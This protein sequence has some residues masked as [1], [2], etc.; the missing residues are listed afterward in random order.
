MTDNRL[1]IFFKQKDYIKE[2]NSIPIAQRIEILKRLRELIRSNEE[3]IKQALSE[4]L[5]KNPTEAY[6]T[7]KLI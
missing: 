7:R 2:Q 4:D 5:H 6:M 1:E 3:K